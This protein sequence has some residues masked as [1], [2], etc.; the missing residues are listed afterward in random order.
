MTEPPA[1]RRPLDPLVLT[2]RAVRVLATTALIAAG[3]L[4]VALT[5]TALRG[6]DAGLRHLYRR[7]TALLMLL[8]PAFVKAGQVLGT[9]RDVL[10]GA[11]CDELS[12]LQDAMPPMTPAQ[13]R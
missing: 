10:P 7:L 13:A 6:R 11:L 4:P 12:L 2:G 1:A 8:G 3:A 9:R 5:L